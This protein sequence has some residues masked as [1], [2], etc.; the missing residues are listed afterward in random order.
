M[1]S[2]NRCTSIRRTAQK[3]SASAKSSDAEAPR[4]DRQIRVMEWLLFSGGREW[5]CSRGREILEISGYGRH[6]NRR[7][8]RKTPSKGSPPRRVARRVSEVVAPAGATKAREAD[9]R[10][11]GGEAGAR[12]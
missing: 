9:R 4:Y 3:P 2:P 1:K 5:V 12:S 11:R 6:S 8:S 10:S 7:R